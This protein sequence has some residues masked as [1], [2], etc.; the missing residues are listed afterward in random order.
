MKNSAF[1][2][3]CSE[4][5][6][7]HRDEIFEWTRKPVGYSSEYYFAKHRWQLKRWFQEQ[8]SIDN[9]RKIQKEIKRS[10]KG[11]NL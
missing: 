6:F 5:W 4:K 11:G 2:H 3:F 10:L 9:A 8:Y 1:R 7:E